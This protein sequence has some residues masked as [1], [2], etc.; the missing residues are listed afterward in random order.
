V[1]RPDLWASALGDALCDYWAAV[2]LES[3]CISP[4]YRPDGVADGP[5]RDLVSWRGVADLA[6]E[7]PTGPRANSALYAA[8]LWDLRARFVRTERDG[9]RIADRLVLQHLRLL[10]EGTDDTLSAA[11]T[12]GRPQSGFSE[13]LGALLRADECLH[14]RQHSA[15]IRSLFGAR[16]IHPAD[17]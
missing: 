6:S 8:S 15:T 12:V 13:A 1:E 10:G 17:E 2:M 9:G 3:P 5:R 16:G 14:Q 11:A 4:W 7:R